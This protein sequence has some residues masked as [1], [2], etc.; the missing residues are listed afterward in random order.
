MLKKYGVELIGASV[1]A[2]KVAEDRLLF[3][4]AMR[5][6][7]ADVPE[8]RYVRSHGRSADG[9]RRH[10]V[11]RPSS[12][13]RSRWAAWAAASPTTSRSSAS[14]RDA[15]SISAPSTKCCSKSR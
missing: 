1:E 9:R 12:G 6:I 14:W 8:S 10:R 13:R 3:R 4:E 7:G 2:I 11:S 5:S 15:A